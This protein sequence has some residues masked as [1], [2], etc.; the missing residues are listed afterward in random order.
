MNKAAREFDLVVW[1]A[2]GFTGRLVAEY[3]AGCEGGDGTLRWAIAGRNAE[4]LAEVASG[5]AARLPKAAMH[6]V[7]RLIADS[8]DLDSLRALAARTRVLISTVGPYAL[9]GSGLVQACAELGTDYV[10]LTGEPHWIRRM[11]DAWQEAARASGARIV[12]CCG[13]DSVPFDMG[14]WYLQRELQA[15]TGRTA[16]EVHG[17]VRRMR[18]GFSGGTFASMLNFVEEAVGDPALR[19][20]AANANAL[21]PGAPVEYLKDGV[22]WEAALETWTGPFVM[23]AINTKTV[24]RSHALLGSPWGP[25]FRYLESMAIGAGTAG[26]LRAHALQAGMGVF[27]LGAALGPTRTLLKRLMPKPGEGPDEAAR[28]SGF[29]EVD[30]VGLGAGGEALG[31]ATVSGDRDPGYGS[32]C[33]LISESALCLVQDTSQAMCGGGIWTPGAAMGL[34]LARRLQERAGLSFAIED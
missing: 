26:R 18:G 20:L 3:L 28:N 9:Y 13:F 1:G 17:V 27:M 7:P 4:R 14:V 25:A 6:A 22:A 16:P 15:R 24:R 30:F 31:I 33:K 19:R 32:T 11:L 5:I 12:H 10:D 2:T 34:A 23:A 8:N 21:L 29:Y